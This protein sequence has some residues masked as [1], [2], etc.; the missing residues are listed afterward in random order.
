[1]PA[2]ELYTRKLESVD[3]ILTEVFG[4]EVVYV[5]GESFKRLVHPETKDEIMLYD[6]EKGDHVAP[7]WRDVFTD[8][9]GIGIELCL[10]VKN[11]SEIYQ[12][13]DKIEEVWNS[14]ITKKPWGTEE[15]YFRLDEGYLFRI[16]EGSL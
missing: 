14:T 10:R 2:I 4:Y 5:H 13:I 9:K 16:I 1:M 7:F 8:Q 3:N 11:L 15:F 6:Y 12:K